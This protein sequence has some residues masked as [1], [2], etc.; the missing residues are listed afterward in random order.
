M[1]SITRNKPS[2]KVNFVLVGLLDI[3][4]VIHPCQWPLMKTNVRTTRAYQR[5]RV[6]INKTCLILSS[7]WLIQM[8]LS[9]VTWDVLSQ[10]ML[11]Y[12]LWVNL[13]I[14]ELIFTFSA[15]MRRWLISIKTQVLTETFCPGGCMWWVIAVNGTL[16]L[17]VKKIWCFKFL[18]IINIIMTVFV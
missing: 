13:E 6:N 17:A 14:A 7:I 5:N 12:M 9:Q 16:I 8:C 2:I 11:N 18:V 15:K 1:L 4:V 3:L 10:R